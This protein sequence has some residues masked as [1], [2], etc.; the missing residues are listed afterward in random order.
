MNKIKSILLCTSVIVMN[1]QADPCCPPLWACVVEKVFAPVFHVKNKIKKMRNER[2]NAQFLKKSALE[3]IEY[4]K[5]RECTYEE[6]MSIA[7]DIQDL[8]FA[9]AIIKKAGKTF[10]I[11]TQWGAPYCDLRTERIFR[12][13]TGNTLLNKAVSYADTQVGYEIVKLLLEHGA[14]PNQ[15]GY[16]AELPLE[17]AF[18]TPKVVA[19]LLEYGANPN[20]ANGLGYVPLHRIIYEDAEIAIPVIELLL[21]YGADINAIKPFDRST[22]LLAAVIEGSANKII[23]HLLKNGADVN[24]GIGGKQYCTPLFVALQKNDYKKVKI[25]LEHG[26]NPN[27]KDLE[28]GNSL[29]W[30]HDKKLIDLLVEYGALIDIK[31][32]EGRTPLHHNVKGI[33]YKGQEEIVKAFINLGIGVDVQD[34]EGKTALDYAIQAKEAGFNNTEIL[35][36]LV[37]KYF[38][39]KSSTD[40]MEYLKRL[41]CSYEEMMYIAIDYQDLEFAQAIFK[42]APEGFDI[43]KKDICYCAIGH[44]GIIRNPNSDGD[45]LLKKAV[46]CVKSEVDCEIVKLLLEHGANPNLQTG[47]FYQGPLHTIGHRNDATLMITLI[48]LLL[49]YG[50]DINARDGEMGRTLL[51]TLVI[52][53]GPDEVITFLLEKGAD[54]CWAL[55][56][57]VHF[58][59]YHQV[60]LLLEH[61]VNPNECDMKGKKLA[62]VA[63]TKEV[64][65]LL[66]KHGVT[67]NKQHL[68]KF[69]CL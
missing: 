62:D 19:L 10:D 44:E 8:E 46:S 25:L 53:T 22:P 16:C 28:G 39:Q 27:K 38:L 23:V 2:L 66:R 67:H 43:N 15:V 21:K 36:L 57:A 51:D 6:M 60:K 37:K 9:Q 42:K 7:I 49:Q 32:N 56:N 50:A 41:G 58:N 59:R 20:Q 11:N 17:T 24:F 1:M 29:F 54:A 48:D 45:T 4:L 40:R 5:S 35:K 3:K 13:Y 31:D 55:A 12:N 33:V 64:F 63:S 18:L 68:I 26:A 65:E 69:G 61:G 47:L 34:V 30:T 14:N 52:H